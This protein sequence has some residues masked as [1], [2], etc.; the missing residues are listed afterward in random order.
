MNKIICWFCK[1]EFSYDGEKYRD[2]DC[3][4]C[5]V[6]NTIYNPANYQPYKPNGKESEREM[7]IDYSS[8]KYS[9]KYVFLPRIGE[10]EIFEIKTIKEVKSDNKKMNFRER[11]TTIIDGEE[12]E[13]EKDLGFHIEAEIEGGK[14]LSVGSMGAFIQVFKNNDI[15][16]NT[17]IEVEH[18]ER[19]VWKVTKL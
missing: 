7:S 17:K 3:D 19:G 1:K 16:D 2:V 15:Q 12:V 14:F 6:E 9:G 13:I 10:K 5:G 4:W 11:R 8:E 18:V